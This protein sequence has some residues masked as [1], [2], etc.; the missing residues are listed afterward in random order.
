MEPTAPVF[1][2]QRFS[3]HDGP[4]IRSLIFLK[5]C[6]LRCPWCQNPESQASRPI[7]AFYRDRCT[8]SFECADACPIGAIQLTGYRVDHTLCDRCALCVDACPYGALKLIGENLTPRQLMARIMVDMPYYESSGGGV[9]FTGG[10]PTLHPSFMRRML[11]LCAEAGVHTNLET[12]GTF[13][14]E[15]WEQTLGMLD[16]IYFDLKILDADL[17]ERHLGGGYSRI[18]KNAENLTRKGFPVEFRMAMVPGHTDTPG[19]IAAA[20]EL[21]KKFGHDAIHL[22]AYHNMGEAKIDI[23]K[24]TQPKLGLARYSD[25]AWHDLV[26]AFEVQG[27]EVVTASM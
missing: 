8:D 18:M 10:E 17:H 21:V 12:A 11:E 14:W 6:A 20:I 26:E 5:G 25:E 19:N 13:S 9:T 1:E 24:G 22:L 23:I 2:I 15:K 3:I 27:I 7:I 4:G 16:L